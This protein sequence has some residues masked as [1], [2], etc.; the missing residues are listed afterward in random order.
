[1]NKSWNDNIGKKIKQ[2]SQKINEK[3]RGGANWMI[4]DP[5]VVQLA[6]EYTEE[7]GLSVE[8]IIYN[9]INNTGLPL[10]V[11]NKLVSKKLGRKVEFQS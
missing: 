1:M 5:L 2:S 11:R 10:D 6:K 8:Q 4:V 7:S 3:S 9:W